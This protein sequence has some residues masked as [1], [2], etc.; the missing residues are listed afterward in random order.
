MDLQSY[1]QTRE[2]NDIRFEKLCEV[3]HVCQICGAKKN[4]DVYPRGF[5]PP[6]TDTRTLDVF[7]IKCL[8]MKSGGYGSTKNER[9]VQKK[10]FRE[11]C[12]YRANLLEQLSIFFQDTLRVTVQRNPYKGFKSDFGFVYKDVKYTF[13]LL[14][15]RHE[16]FDK[17]FHGCEQNYQKMPSVFTKKTQKS[18]SQGI[19][20]TFLPMNEEVYGVLDAFFQKNAIVVAK[21]LVYDGIGKTVRGFLRRKASILPFL[22]AKQ[23]FYEN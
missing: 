14:D 15:P 17:K 22:P 13:A 16:Y 18:A 10:A 4:I 19:V 6:I 8:R 1:K 9:F 5:N 3:G 12:R 2:W 11:L 7:C 21:E 23:Y 20:H